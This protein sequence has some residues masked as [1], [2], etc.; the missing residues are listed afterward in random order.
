MK[1]PAVKSILAAMIGT[2]IEWFDYGLFGYLA[3][4]LAR[5]F[6]PAY[7]NKWIGLLQAFMVFAVG[8]LLRPLG[9]VI[10]GSLADRFGR[11]VILRTTILMVSLPSI[12]IACLPT[13]A[14][15]GSAST[16]LLIFLRLSQ[17]ISLG[18]EF[19]GA[20]VYITE[21][22]PPR[23]RTLFSGL[24]NNASNIGILLGVGI[25]SLLTSVLSHADFMT[26]GWRIPF[27]L[28][29]L[30]GL[31]GY[32]LRKFFLESDLFLRLQQEKKLH[33]QPIHVIF[34]QNKIKLLTG[35]ALCC[36]GAC[37]IYT[38]TTYLTTYLQIVKHY[39]L[40]TALSLQSVL[41]VF[42]LFLVPLAGIVA[43]RYGRIKILKLAALGNVFYSGAAFFYLPENHIFLVALILLPLIIFCSMEQG[44]MPATLAEFFPTAIRYSSV[45]I[46][47]NIS[48][49]YI[50]GT[51]PMYITW[52]INQTHNDLIPGFCIAIT[53][54]ITGLALL[55][56]SRSNKT[57]TKQAFITVP[58]I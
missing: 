15:I 46:A 57:L 44:I 34:Q 19:A 39:P 36:M 17:G 20:M 6:F 47:Y 23:F 8:F 30:S 50:G 33:A 32:R 55:K 49:A 12:L 31:A 37:S 56:I 51:A 43:N 29:G 24:V 14:M 40:N 42:T 38:L 10:F 27:L 45:S 52:L 7:N 48:Y 54:A 58:Q 2:T 1:N 22:S 21:I 4:I 3:P 28:G 41:L 35:I 16:F 13:Y 18:G 25:C 5:L 26:F 11:V 9:G 53:A